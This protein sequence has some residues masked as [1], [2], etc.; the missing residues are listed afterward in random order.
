MVE[1]RGGQPDR[2]PSRSIPHT[3]GGGGEPPTSLRAASSVGALPRGVEIT[4][5]GEPP[6]CGAMGEQLAEGAVFLPRLQ[7]R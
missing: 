7:R 6:V 2:P 1:H 4:E 5:L 3:S